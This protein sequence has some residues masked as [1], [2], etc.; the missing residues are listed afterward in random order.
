MPSYN[1][2]D[3]V[4]SHANKWLLHDL[5]RK[6]WGFK[7]M[8]VSDY[9]GVEQLANK[10]FVAEDNKDAARIAFNSGVQFEFPQA[11]AYRYLPELLKE[12]K[13][14]KADFDK[15]VSQVLELKFMLGLF[16]NPYVDLKDS[17]KSK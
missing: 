15:A 13:I 6:E 8:I 17:Y 14:N 3:G 7:G 9:Y 16:E 12:G 2:V 5:L 10:H 11:N 4:P 1:E